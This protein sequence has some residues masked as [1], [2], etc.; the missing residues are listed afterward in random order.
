MT[1]YT[2]QL[3]RYKK[4]RRSMSDHCHLVISA[5]TTELVSHNVYILE[6]LHIAFVPLK[7][8]WIAAGL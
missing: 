3:V 5:F 2:C 1:F 7:M 4:D 6:S 8:L